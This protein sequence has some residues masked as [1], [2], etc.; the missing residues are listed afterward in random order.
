MNIFHQINLR[1][2]S[3]KLNINLLETHFL[4]MFS[5]FINYC[6]VNVEILGSQNNQSFQSNVDTIK[7]V[8]P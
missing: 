3:E 4:N 2:E 1:I 8:R 6:Q 5:L 7:Y